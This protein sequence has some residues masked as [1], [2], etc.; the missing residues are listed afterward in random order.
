MAKWV[1]T[2]FYDRFESTPNIKPELYRQ[3][4]NSFNYVDELVF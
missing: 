4:R 2:G 1:L 3:T